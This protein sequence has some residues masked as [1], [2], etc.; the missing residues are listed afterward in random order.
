MEAEQDKQRLIASMKRQQMQRIIKIVLIIAGCVLISATVVVLV[1]LLT[2]PKSGGDDDQPSITTPNYPLFQKANKQLYVWSHSTEQKIQG[3]PA[4]K[5]LL[6]NAD[7]SFDKLIA[8]CETHNFRKVYLFAGSVE[9][10]YDSDFSRG[11]F[12]CQ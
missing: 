11:E 8:F 7:G 2:K 10:E 5:L 9:W 12:P 4:W 3:Q 1:V 6:Q